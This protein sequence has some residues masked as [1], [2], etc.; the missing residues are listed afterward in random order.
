MTYSPETRSYRDIT[1]TLTNKDNALE[2]LLI[3]IKSSTPGK[4]IELV[5]T[6]SNV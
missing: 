5:I 6:S 3:A 1:M 2:V 4:K